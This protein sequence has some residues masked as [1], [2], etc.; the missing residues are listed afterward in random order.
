MTKQTALNKKLFSILWHFVCI[1]VIAGF[2]A[3]YF[4]PQ[5][6]GKV[7][8]QEDMVQFQGMGKDAKN[9]YKETGEPSLWT[10]SMFGGMP[11]YMIAAPQTNNYV[12]QRLNSWFMLKLGK[13]AGFFVIAGLCMYIFLITIDL[14]RVLAV[15]G[16]LVY[17]FVTNNIILLDVGHISK[18]QVVAYLPLAMAGIYA[19]YHK[20]Q[21]VW[22][23]LLF[24]IGMA[25]NI[26]ST[27]YQMT[28]YFALGLAI[29]LII[30]FGLS[31]KNGG[32]KDFFTA[33]LVAFIAGLLS[34]GPA[35]S[36]LYTTAE[37][38][39]DTMRGTSILSQ[40]K[41]APAD[42]KSTDG[43]SGLEWDYA[44]TWSYAPRDAWRLISP[45]IM[46]GSSQMEVD[47]DLPIHKFF[48][49]QNRRQKVYA[50]IYWGG[51]ESVAGPAYVGAIFLLLLI[52]GFFVPNK[53]LFWPLF[54]GLMLLIFISFGKYFES[55]QRIFFDYFPKYSSFRAHNSVFAVVALFL[56]AIGIHSLIEFFKLNKD[57]RRRSLLFTSITLGVLFLILFA[58]PVYFS[59]EHMSDVRFE[60]QIK[61]QNTLDAFLDALEESRK[62]IYMDSLKRTLFISLIGLGVLFAVA[63]EKL[64]TVYAAGILGLVMV[65]DLINIDLQYVNHDSFETKRKVTNLNAMRPV[66]E[67]ILKNE[68]KGR[69]YYRVM[70]LSINTFNSAKT[71]FYHNT[72]GG[73][74]PVKL[75]RIQDVIDST[76]RPR[77]NI[78]V[79][80]MLN[81]KYIIDQN[82]QLQTNPTA[83]GN[84]WFVDSIALVDKNY[85][86]LN[87]LR[88]INTAT[89]ASVHM[90]YQDI[91]G[92]DLRYN[93]QNGK[94]T[95]EEYSTDR[96]VYKS[97]NT[98]K[99]FAVFSEAWYGPDK[100]WKAFIDKEEVPILRVNYML[101]GLKV[102]AGSHEIVF[103]FKPQKYY[104][105]NQV[106]G[107]TSI[108]IL[109]FLA[110]YVGFS[111]WQL[112]RT[113][114]KAE[115][116]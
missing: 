95:L 30:Q 14:N 85:K 65:V 66:D 40:D 76:F 4:M 23:G 102:P 72:V 100:G 70:D 6:S 33:S 105:G 32:V 38:A 15:S 104:F 17:A 45:T 53:K 98:E 116:G 89:T 114:Q 49:G 52:L 69:G 71:S 7:L 91:L 78:G 21:W 34:V 75:Q 56:C 112:I 94:I 111:V 101:R 27:H 90:E 97:E 36:K 25:M 84:G 42:I 68:P 92:E 106:S 74:S 50:P 73:Y 37:Y 82:G 2:S 20:R 35:F 61:D 11:N 96:L 47:K 63:T 43:G 55:L 3:V 115:K 81:A 93:G 9:Q 44:M 99:G 83:L 60:S 67:S 107:A 8:A 48:Q 79:L 26:S 88:T 18:L 1:L 103:E 108:M 109:L 80:N 19:L 22:G 16:G 64:K 12:Y 29:F 62:S 41:E 28:Y 5:F 77:L 86:E 59:F 13:P 57:Q 110:G 10:N 113:Y 51:A 31:I 58:G 39:E 87:A 46:G 54:A 24:C